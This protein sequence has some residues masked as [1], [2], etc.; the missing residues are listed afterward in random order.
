MMEIREITGDEDDILVQHYLA[1]WESYR[2]PKEHLLADAD[3]RVRQFI[4]E[5]REQRRLGAFFALIDGKRVG[6]AACGLYVSPYPV[7]RKP[8]I[9]LDGY[10]WHVFVDAEHRGKGIATELVKAAVGHLQ[11]LGCTKVIL[12]ASDAGEGVY[13]RIGFELAKEMRLPLADAPQA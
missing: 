7:V 3:A 5:A 4:R 11:S 6:S 8:E 9:Q 10:I 1:I 2:T 12:H 13:R